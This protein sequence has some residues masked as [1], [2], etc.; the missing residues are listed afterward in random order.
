MKRH[1]PVSAVLVSALMI[2]AAPSVPVGAQAP[3]SI[4]IE[5]LASQALQ[6]IM[7]GRHLDCIIVDIGISAA[8]GFQFCTWLTENTQ[9]PIVVLSTDAS[10]ESAQRAFGCGARAYVVK[11]FT[12]EVI[13]ERLA[14]I[15]RSP[16]PGPGSPAGAASP[17]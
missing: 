9:A 3:P 15:F 4:F 16:R 6:L 12:R 2:W 17:G 13:L 1:I 8:D 7:E 10:K 5:E 14:E 11:P